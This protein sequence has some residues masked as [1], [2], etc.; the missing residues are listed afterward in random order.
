MAPLAVVED[1]QVLEDG[2]GELHTCRP[3]LSVEQLHLHPTPE[4]LH[5]GVVVA[6]ANRAHGWQETRVNG[7]SGKRPRRE[8]RSLITVD[9]GGSPRLALVDG[10]TERVGDERSAR[11]GVD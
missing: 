9:D 4:R 1:L 5:H 8:L 7:A 3:A 2:A 6:V 11:R 10:H